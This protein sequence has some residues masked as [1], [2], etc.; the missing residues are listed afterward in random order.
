[1]WMDLEKLDVTVPLGFLE[2]VPGLEA[3]HETGAV[4]DRL[5]KTNRLSWNDCADQMKIR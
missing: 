3:P 4:E 5:F 2:K 1:V